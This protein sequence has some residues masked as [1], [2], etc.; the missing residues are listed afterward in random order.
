MLMVRN[1]K[2]QTKEYWSVDPFLHSPIFGQYM[3]RDRF[4]GIQR[5]LHFVNNEGVQHNN[6]LYKIE[7]ILDLIRRTFSSIFY[8][9]QNLV[10]D[11]SLI[12][13]KG[14]LSFKQYI[15]T[16]RHRFGIKLY[17]LCDCDT[18]IVL[19]FLVYTGKGNS[20]SKNNVVGL[21]TSG[22]VVVDLMEPYL[23]KGHSLFT[24]NF[25]SSPTLSNYL[26]DR[27]TNSCGTVRLNRLHMPRF[28]NK[29]KKR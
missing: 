26:F 1:K 11:E 16:K 27:K 10:I 3:A 24:D 2:L 9:F 29:L 8:P 5:C 6:R 4:L 21:G 13:F 19:D 15:K 22:N 14:R 18:G 20:I 28:E 17:V 12:L 23:D 7:N 25:Y